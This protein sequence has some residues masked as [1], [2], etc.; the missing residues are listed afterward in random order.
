MKKLLFGVLCVLLAIAMC[1]CSAETPAPLSSASLSVAAYPA[2]ADSSSLPTS[3]SQPEESAPAPAAPPPLLDGYSEYQGT[4]YTI[5]HPVSWVA[6]TEDTIEE[7]FGNPENV[8]LDAMGE[9][10]QAYIE[11][12]FDGGGMADADVYF[13]DFENATEQ[14][15][16]NVN[17]VASDSGGITLENMQDSE[18][19]AQ[20]QEMLVGMYSQ[21]TDS[22]EITAEMSGKEY[23][24]TYFV[25]FQYVMEGASA[26]SCITIADDV[27]Y[28]ITASS[29]GP[30]D[31]P[32]YEKM[33]ETFT[34]V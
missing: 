24:G 18:F 25:T 9:D 19:Q 3:S 21:M 16:P 13:F 11:S 10:A 14:S 5:Q 32:T 33:L 1:A 23:G 17:I 2:S 4:G 28:T 7:M 12:L 29:G 30:L 8:A 20:L 15:T 26:L 34:V 31:M 27:Q 22:F 6:F